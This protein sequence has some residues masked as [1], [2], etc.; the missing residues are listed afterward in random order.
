[1]FSSWLYNNNPKP[2][3]SFGNGS[4]MRVSPIG[5]FYNDLVA[6]VNKAAESAIVSHTHIEGIKGA[7][8]VA[9]SIYLARSTKN[10]E[11][12]KDFIKDYIGYD[13]NKTIEEIKNIYSFNETC[14]G[15]VPESIICFLEG[16]NYED[17]IRKAISLNGDTDTM[18]C[19]A[20]G[21]A[22][23]FYGIPDNISAKIN[24]YL[25]GEMLNI[26]EQYKMAVL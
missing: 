5:W 24:E 22:E 11:K 2:Y 23:A 10:K 4:A 16:N 26:V 12:V 25:P 20:G 19:I 8:A 17:V 7:C 13:L 18:A 15:S 3:D 21:I 9:G 6:V 14:Q 1:M